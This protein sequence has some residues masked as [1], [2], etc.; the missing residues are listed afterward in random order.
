[1]FWLAEVFNGSYSE[2]EMR[3]LER[4][5]HR[6]RADT[7]H[8]LFS[9]LGG[10]L[11]G[12]VKST[13]RATQAAARG[14]GRGYR[15]VR[16]WQRRR[17]AIRELNALSDHVLKDIGLARGDIPWAVAAML[18]KE[19]T[20]SVGTRRPVL[21]RVSTRRPAFPDTGEHDWQRAA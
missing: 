8:H 9:A 5:A 12:A 18:N 1:M 19:S 16:L 13:G 15:T 4:W 11:V 14:L 3:R 6:R 17:A 10:G 20:T 2:Q 7:V 21:Q